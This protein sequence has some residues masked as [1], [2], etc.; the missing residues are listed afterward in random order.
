[1]VKGDF[2]TF[3]KQERNEA[4]LLFLFIHFLLH[5]FHSCL[6]EEGN[7]RLIRAFCTDETQSL[8]ILSRTSLSSCVHPRRGLSIALLSPSAAHGHLQLSLAVS[9]S[10]CSDE[11]T[12]RSLRGLHC[13]KDCHAHPPPSSPGPPPLPTS[14]LSLWFPSRSTSF[15]NASQTM[16]FPVAHQLCV[17]AP[18]HIYWE[19]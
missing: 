10:Q 1:M 3:L 16:A 8:D 13:P 15:R 4:T 12:T 11:C 19:S 18:G 5:P 2:S 6:K 17:C 7:Q 14:L 9:R